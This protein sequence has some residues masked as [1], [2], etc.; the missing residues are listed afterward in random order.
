V[1]PKLKKM[2]EAEKSKAVEVLMAAAKKTL[3]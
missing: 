1:E 3:I 2:L